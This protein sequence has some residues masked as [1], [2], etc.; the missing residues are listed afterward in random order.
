[1]CD[2]VGDGFCFPCPCSGHD[3]KRAIKVERRFSLALVE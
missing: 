2:P 1:M 3:E